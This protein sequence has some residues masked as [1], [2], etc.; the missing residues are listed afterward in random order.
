M[1]VV[2]NYY[3]ILEIPKSYYKLSRAVCKRTFT[4]KDLLISEG[5]QQ[6]IS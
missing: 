5:T 1:R 3:K 2:T 4:L 6:P